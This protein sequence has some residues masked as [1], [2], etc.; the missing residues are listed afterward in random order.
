MKNATTRTLAQAGV[1][2]ALY[3]GLTL[4]LPVFS[5]GPL[6]FRL[7]EVLTILPAFTVAAVPGLTLGCLL[8]NG[9][10][11][12]FG[13]NLAGGWDLLVGTGATLLA[14]LCA[15]ALRGARIK[16]I[17]VWSALPAVVFNT[18][19]IGAELCFAVFDGEPKSLWLCFA[20]VGLGELVTA[21]LGGVLLALAL[22]RTGAEKH[23]FGDRF[24]Q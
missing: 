8:A 3:A 14:S 15:Y 23:I 18:G 17:P 19:L 4:L 24:R 11:L 7:S 13:A 21:G 6:Q 22:T 12:A 5:F 10:G 20:Q 16:N 2:A 9:F 1:I